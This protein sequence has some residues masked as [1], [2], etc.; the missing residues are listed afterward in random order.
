MYYTYFV[1]KKLSIW[2]FMLLVGCVTLGY[3]CP[4]DTTALSTKKIILLPSICLAGS[5]EILPRFTMLPM[6]NIVLTLW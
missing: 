3:Y 5:S 4:I 2:I 1:F 6:I